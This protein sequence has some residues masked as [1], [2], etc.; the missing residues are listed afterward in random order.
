MSA[1]PPDPS[2]QTQ[3]TAADLSDETPAPETPAPEIK[4]PAPW[5]NWW[6]ELPMKSIILSVLSSAI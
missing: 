5:V 2:E 4:A 3:M 6:Q 1:L